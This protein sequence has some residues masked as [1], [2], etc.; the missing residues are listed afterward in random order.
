MVWQTVRSFTACLSKAFREAYKG[1]R[2]ALIGSEGGEEPW[3][4]CV[5]DTSNAI[6]FAIGAMFVREVFHGEA[7]PQAEEMINEVRTAFQRNLR[8]LKWMDPETR[9][10]ADQKA[11]A[12]SDMIGFPDYILSSSLLDD[13]YKDLDIDPGKYFEN[14]KRINMFNLRQNLEKLDQPV[15]K[16]RWGMTPPT[17]NAY[18]T[19][20]KNQIVFPAG[21]LQLPFF[22]IKNPKSLNFG[23]MGVVMG[24]ELTHAFDDQGRQYDKYGNLHQWWNDKTIEKFKERTNCLA[25]QYG[26]YE[27]NGK[28]LNG[29]QTLGIYNND[30]S[31]FV[32][33]FLLSINFTVCF[34]FNQGPFSKCINSFQKIKFLTIN[35]F[36]KNRKLVF[37]STVI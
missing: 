9:K 18:Y 33:L 30:L 21:I 27:I 4:Y 23:G 19:P 32:S 25:R 14:N 28:R 37:N 1:L 35:I 8:N 10:L 11:N 20:T 22:D 24:H 31:L 34:Y 26:K 36:N 12:I 7:K 29:K 2:K 17:V 3:R 6:G 15:N 13:K 16:T 5:T